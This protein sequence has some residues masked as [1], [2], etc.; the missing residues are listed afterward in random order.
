[1]LRR[2]IYI[3][4]AVA[5]LLA[6]VGGAMTLHGLH[7]L[8]VVFSAMMIWSFLLYHHRLYVIKQLHEKEDSL[9]K[10]HFQHLAVCQSL[11]VLQ[12][13]ESQQTDELSNYQEQIQELLEEKKSLEAQLSASHLKYHEFYE[14]ELTQRVLK[15]TE[16]PSHRATKK[17]REQLIALFQ[18]C[19]PNFVKAMRKVKM[20][21]GDWEIIILTELGFQT[22][23]ISTVLGIDGN[24]ITA[25]KRSLSKRM[26]GQEGLSFFQM[27]L[28]AAVVVGRLNV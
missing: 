19:F 10:L 4:I 16:P 1:M 13:R 9:F 5:S 24:A 3:S 27:N 14:S 28:H 2:I 18:G 21:E 26:F 17:E 8:I 22:C 6:V 11:K 23:D 15:M 25:R 7:L 20:K 12:E